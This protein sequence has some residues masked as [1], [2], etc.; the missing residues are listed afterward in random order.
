MPKCSEMRM[1]NQVRG[2]FKELPLP[3]DECGGGE[4]AAGNFDAVP[5]TPASWGERP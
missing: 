1:R 2:K 4:G 3:A 5:G